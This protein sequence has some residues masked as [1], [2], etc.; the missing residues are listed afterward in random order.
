MPG[1][2][3]CIV[4]AELRARAAYSEPDRH[5][6]N[7][8]HLEECLAELD[9][10]Q[11][12]SERDRRLLRWAILW[13]E[14][15]YE[16]GQKTNEQRSAELAAF[17]LSRCGVA[18]EDCAEAVRLILLTERH[19]TDQ[20]DRLG[21]L[22]I[23]IDLAILGSDPERYNDYAA[24]VRREYGHVPD[25]LW[26][27]GRSLVLSRL[28]EA[29]PLYPDHDFGGRLEAQAHAN[30]EAEISRLGEG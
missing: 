22:M 17:E 18:E 3:E 1:Y 9:S 12:L 16:P 28:L 14:A 6:H 10:V 15:V 27:T 24:G 13:H 23:S 30:M 5:Y 2:D 26:R 25:E 4:E 21:S 8:R 20:G 29:D 7:E 19:R 11:G